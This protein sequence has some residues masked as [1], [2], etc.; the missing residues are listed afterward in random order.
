M[1]EAICG[2]EFNPDIASEL[3]LQKLVFARLQFAWQ[4]E[5]TAPD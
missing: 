4:T 5:Q 3:S 1:S 2:N